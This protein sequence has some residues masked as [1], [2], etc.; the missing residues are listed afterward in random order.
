MLENFKK[1]LIQKGYS[2]YTPSG[3][4]STVYDYIKRVNKIC[5]RENISIK[6]LSE[7]IDDYVI[8][9][10]TSGSEEKFGKKSHSAFINALRRFK[11]F[12]K[13]NP[14]EFEGKISPNR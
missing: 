6:Q 11:E 4:P 3:N 12:R 9:Y 14:S 13:I 1:Y 7:Q 2:E 10:D 5:E 8:K